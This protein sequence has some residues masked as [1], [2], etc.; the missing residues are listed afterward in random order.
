MNEQRNTLTNIVRKG[1]RAMVLANDSRVLEPVAANLLRWEIAKTYNRTHEHGGTT[2]SFSAW[3]EV[4][5][6]QQEPDR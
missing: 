5:R 2:L 4:I 3:E 6:R 1:I